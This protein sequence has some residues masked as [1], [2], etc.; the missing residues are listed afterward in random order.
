MAPY[1]ETYEDNNLI[2]EL[3]NNMHG[4]CIIFNHREIDPEIKQILESYFEKINKNYK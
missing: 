1:Y 3:S 4:A 2:Y